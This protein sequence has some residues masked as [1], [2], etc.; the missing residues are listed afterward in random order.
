VTDLQGKV[1]LVTGGGTGIGA[2]VAR[3][4]AAAGAEVTVTGRRVE[5]LSEVVDAITSTG[6]AALA[7]SADVT[8]FDAMQQAVDGA[9]ARFGRLD[10]VV[11]NAGI[12]PPVAPALDTS[13]DDWRTIVDVD[14]TGVFITAKTTVPTLRAAGGGAL[15]VVGSG[16][17]RA[18]TGGLGA[19]S[20]AKAGVTALCR[21][22][23]A[24]LR[25]DRIAVNELVPGPV[26]TPALDIVSDSSEEERAERLRRPP[27]GRVS[28][29]G[30]SDRDAGTLR[31]SERAEYPGQVFS[32]AGR[33][34]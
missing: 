34:L 32:L 25:S 5:P 33:L 6:G 16:A 29:R 30:A 15:I 26:R 12:A 27:R 22:L 1:A 24:E 20:A 2:A 11:A 4:Y 17:G 14:L 31:R 23:A 7:A 19:Y 18:N 9:V 21:V 13:I 3:A 10:I 28:G 8:D